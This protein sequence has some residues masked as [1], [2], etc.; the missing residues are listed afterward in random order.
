M[1]KYFKV[2]GLVPGSEIVEGKNSLK[3]DVSHV[4]QRSFAYNDADVL[5]ARQ[6]GN[7]IWASGGG[8]YLLNGRYL[9]VVQRPVHV[10]VNP[11]KFSLFT[12][13]AD[14]EA[15]LL[16][17]VLLIR[18][19]FEELVLFS[20]R[21]LY[22]PIC[23]G[24]QEI[25]DQVYERLITDL[26]IR[27]IDAIPLYL[28]HL[29]CAPKTIS[30]TNHGERWE[31]EFDC[32]VNNNGEVNIVFVLSGEVDIRTLQAL[33]GEYHLSEGSAVSQNRKIYL[34][35][36]QSGAG[37]DISNNT[38]EENVSIP[39]DNMTEHLRDLVTILRSKLPVHGPLLGD[40]S[41]MGSK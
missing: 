38:H 32:H 26:Q 34:Y 16:N 7:Y 30:V 20:G 31:G 11:G 40:G 12:G 5:A 37:T 13:R 41:S 6:S 23:E 35:D 3:V 15:E 9:L 2:A 25:V 33:D 8:T 17:P 21:Q 29:L 27:S 10:K 36:L 39:E 28:N 14:N 22:K 19:L 18:E 24:F 1:S 4:F